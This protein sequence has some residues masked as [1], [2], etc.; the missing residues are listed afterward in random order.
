[1][2]K[3]RNDTIVTRFPPEPSGHPHAGHL[4]AIYTNLHTA[5]KSKGYTIL[6]FDDTNPS[7]STQEYVD[8]ILKYYTTGRLK[9]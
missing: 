3:Q 2:S 7:T 9:T 5:E 8:S 1:M 4:K 6:R